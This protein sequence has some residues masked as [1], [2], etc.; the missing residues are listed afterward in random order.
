MGALPSLREV[1]SWETCPQ[2]TPGEQHG[3]VGMRGQ[4]ADLSC[5]VQLRG[6]VPEPENLP[7]P[8]PTCL[9]HAG[10]ATYT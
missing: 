8:Q 6:S 9:I 5:G 4:P 10:A 7:F 3:A 2:G 1:G